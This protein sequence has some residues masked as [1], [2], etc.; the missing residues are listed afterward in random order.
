MRGDASDTMG[1]WFLPESSVRS[2]DDA[3]LCLTAIDCGI[4]QAPV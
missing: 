2:R 3:V 1:E 4:R